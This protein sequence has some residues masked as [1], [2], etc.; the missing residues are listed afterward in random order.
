MTDDTMSDS[1]RQAGW[2]PAQSADLEQW[3]EGHRDRASSRTG[4]LH[5]VVERLRAELD[6]D[7]LLRMGVTRMIDQV[8][9]LSLIHI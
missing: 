4:P 1:R 7:P 8:P 6:A 3:I 5:P 2:I 9:H